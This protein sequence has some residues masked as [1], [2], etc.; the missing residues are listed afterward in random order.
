MDGGVTLII[1]FMSN[2][3]FSIGNS[4]QSRKNHIQNMIFHSTNDFFSA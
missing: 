3:T 4:I 2:V 1:A